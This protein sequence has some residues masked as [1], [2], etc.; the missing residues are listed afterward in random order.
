MPNRPTAWL[1]FGLLF[2]PAC[3]EEVS[4]PEVKTSLAPAPERRMPELNR[5]DREGFNPLSAELALPLCWLADGDQ[6]N[7]IAPGE[8]AVLWRVAE[9]TK[10]DWVKDGAFTDRFL[11]AYERLV[12]RKEKGF[13]NPDVANPKGLQDPK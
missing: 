4:K 5:V 12:A 7:A 13:V 10:A 3:K 6:N 2:A 9:S 1:L 8:L 11:D